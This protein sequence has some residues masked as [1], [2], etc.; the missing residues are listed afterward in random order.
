[1]KKSQ[2]DFVIFANP[3]HNSH[4]SWA[5]ICAHT[6]SMVMSPAQNLQP[7]SNIHWE[8]CHHTK[9]KTKTEIVREQEL[10][11]DSDLDWQPS[12]QTLNTFSL[13][14]DRV[15]DLSFDWEYCHHCVES[16]TQN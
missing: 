16:F 13:G 15:L 1:M 2:L 3:G 5:R 9:L 6:P 4:N 14:C 12:T 11:S 8:Y 10:R 7:G